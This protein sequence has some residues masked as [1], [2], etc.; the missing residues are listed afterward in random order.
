[1]DRV[2]LM[3]TNIINLEFSEDNVTGGLRRTD[4]PDGSKVGCES[5]RDFYIPGYYELSLELK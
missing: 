3:V 2:S 4:G 5:G 1:M